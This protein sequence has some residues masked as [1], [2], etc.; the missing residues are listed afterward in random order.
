[1]FENP[2]IFLM[3]AVLSAAMYWAIPGS[4]VRTRATALILFSALAIFIVSPLAL[5]LCAG[6]TLL[7]FFSVFAMGHLPRLAVLWTGIGAIVCTVVVMELFVVELTLFS[8]IGLSYVALKSISVIVD[9]WDTGDEASRPGLLETFLLN[10]FF[11]IFNA[12]PIERL[13]TFRLEKLA[14]RFDYRH[15]IE[16]ICRISLGLFKTSFLY[17]GLIAPFL[18]SHYGS[19]FEHPAAFSTWDF[20]A[21][22]LLNFLALYLNFSGYTDIAVGTGRLYSLQ[23]M[24]NFRFPFLS[25][26][27]QNFWQRWHLSLGAFVNRY[28]FMWFVRLTNG[29]VEL[30][31]I[32]SFVLV[33][34]WHELSL[35]Y[36]I[37][38][39]LHGS[40]LAAVAR[41]N[42][43]AG[44]HEAVRAVRGNAVYWS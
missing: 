42:R 37:W 16:G 13:E 7:V 44:R 41:M 31:L 6:L 36:L 33:G 29:Q 34:L 3:F 38:G 21:Y 20:Y 5:G 10:A 30:S 43:L 9:H 23:I 24:E 18:E 1:M 12:G 19:M 8:T 40:A 15:L 11:P 35:P 28:L 39:L 25:T 27:I 2:Q 22:T 14:A 17:A 4:M 32:L 26:N